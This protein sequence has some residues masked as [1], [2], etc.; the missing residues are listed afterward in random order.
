MLYKV[1]ARVLRSMSLRMAQGM[2]VPDM[3]EELFA[4]YRAQS[5]GSANVILSSFASLMATD[6]GLLKCQTFRSPYAMA[7]RRKKHCA[8]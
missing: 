3:L 8:G 7:R 2:V 6:V 1:T 4:L 5:T